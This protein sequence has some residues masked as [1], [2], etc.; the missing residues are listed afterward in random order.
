M[1]T[2]T[3]DRRPAGEPEFFT[4]NWFPSIHH[5]RLL[6]FL[7]CLGR[8]WKLCDFSTFKLRDFNSEQD[9]KRTNCGRN[10]DNVLEK[11]IA[12]SSRNK[13]R[14]KKKISCCIIR[15]SES[16]NFFC[17]IHTILHTVF[18][19]W[20]P[21]RTG[22]DNSSQTQI[23]NNISSVVPFYIWLHKRALLLGVWK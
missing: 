7:R 6:P 23:K 18:L 10:P 4:A 19:L 5:N 20:P 3:S 9:L 17:K 22:G 2:P 14:K 12:H 16:L 1:K 11:Q 15:K 13:N 8:R 21:T